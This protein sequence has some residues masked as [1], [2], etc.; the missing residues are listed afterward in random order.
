[1]NSAIH[2]LTVGSLLALTACQ[3]PRQQ[4]TDSMTSHFYL[5][6]YSTKLGHVDGKAK[7]ITYWSLDNQ[8]GALKKEAGPWPIVN[9]S[10]LCTSL[11]GRFLYAISETSSYDGREDGYLTSFSINPQTG[12]LTELGTTSSHGVGPAYVSMDRSGDYVLVA[13]YLAGNIVVYP[14]LKSGVLG[15]PT[16]NIPHSGSSVNPN[17]QEAPHPHAIVAS[18]DNQHILVP[19]LGIDKI[20]VYEFD[21]KTGTL[22]PQPT[23]DVTVPA[24]AGPRHL[25]FHPNGDYVYVTLEMA[26][27]VAAYQYQDATLTLVDIYSTLPPGFSGGNTNAELRITGNG[28]FLYASNRGHDSIAAF[29][30][31][32]ATGELTLIQTVS[33]QGRTPRNFAIDPSDQF[34]VVGNQ[35]SHTILSYR[36][37]DATG[38][39]STTGNQTAAPSPVLFHFD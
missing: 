28:Q 33:T 26:N 24:G 29:K 2:F 11:D 7:G 4:R 13:N 34:L 35:D 36:I 32:T 20:K 30:I 15:S 6:T 27:Q 5:G 16:A 17:R 21:D 23:R 22:E 1:M 37:D 18:P 8:T 25:V 19:D 12:D 9:A 3:S 38:E 10:H 14:R 39:L 31:N